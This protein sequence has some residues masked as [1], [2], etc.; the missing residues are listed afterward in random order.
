[1]GRPAM[2]KAEEPSLKSS[3]AAELATGPHLQF[4][5]TPSGYQLL[6][7]QGAGTSGL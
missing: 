7:Q 6:E 5:S 2:T 4:V 3:E 1:M